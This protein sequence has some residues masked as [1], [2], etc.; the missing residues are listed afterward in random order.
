MGVLEADGTLRAVN[1]ALAGVFG[2]EPEVVVGECVLEL[3][4]P[5]DAGA[6]AAAL[7]TALESPD[8]SVSL[9][10]RLLRPDGSWREVGGSLTNALNDPVVSGLVLTFEAASG[11][12]EL[13]RRNRDLETRLGKRTAQ[14]A[15][16]LR[17][18]E[19]SAELL[20]LSQER[21]R[22]LVSNASDLITIL[23]ADG[24]IRY[25]SPAIERLLGY[26]E[27]ELIGRNA[28]DYVHPDDLPRLCSRFEGVERG[29]GAR[30]TA[31][32]RFRHSNGSWRYLEAIATNLIDDPSVAGIVVN[33]RDVTERRQAE[34][35]RS[36]SEALYR[37][38]IERAAEN[39]FIVDVET[40]GII[41][42]NEALSRSLGYPPDEL[43][44]M[45]FYDIVAHDRE[46]VD[47]DIRWILQSGGRF[48]GERRYRGKNGAVVTVEVNV[49]AITYG[50]REALCI[51]AHD[52]TERKRAE[53]SLR[54]SLGVLLALREAGQVLGSTL[55]STEIVS[56]LLEIMQHVS[57]LDAT[58]IS[59]LDESGRLSV[60]RS[61]GL[62]TLRPGIRF[63]P[64]AMA[65]RRAAL[66]NE[67][68]V[69]RP[70]DG[71]LQ[72]NCQVV[73]C[74]PL[75]ARDKIIGVLEAFGPESLAQDDTVQILS[76]LTGQAASA[77]ENARLYKDLEER[78]QQLQ[79]LIERLLAAQEEERRRVAYEVH[80]GLA[81]VAA[82][83]HQHLQ[84]FARRYAPDTEKGRQDLARVLKLV[85]ATVSDARRI[86]ANLRPTTLD[87]FGLATTLSVEAETL[88][89]EGYEVDCRHNL[90]ED[91]LS[92]PVEI[93][94]FRVAQEAL[95]NMR[96]HSDARY[97]RIVL[98][99]QEG[100]V[101]LEV[102]D[103]GRGF[104]PATMSAGSGPGERV[105]L[106]GMRERVS[107]LGGRLE[108]NS[109]PG[110]GTSVIATVPLAGVA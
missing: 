30:V 91:R 38:V 40:R 39:I 105:G 64:E 65:A 9:T 80:D 95:N 53:D 28:F 51:V 7:A 58:V 74:I 107:M 24:T 66:R 12:E 101:R 110:Y 27:D 87:D 102:S 50:G 48:V 42:A 17:E 41:E 88:R 106:A 60:R 4:H 94:L 109:R 19:D 29:S 14:L 37:T 45:V 22:S 69:F 98:Q 78:E 79:D 32:F 3:V 77:L 71:Y 31:E 6:A 34:E 47:D 89:E 72:A 5:E 43:R 26:G 25:E 55:E 15:A 85:R 97:V 2:R 62:N 33:S 20:R 99:R 83:A 61:L 18:V 70:G 104:D 108:I 46:S 73:L 63:V 68:T 11:R 81:Q 57:R 92:H 75:K 100:E 52:I 67:T 13:L 21:F 10:L 84:A 36:R 90:A 56:R 35:D 96:K 1:S 44:G 103:F 93:A 54:E 8:E 23:D 16:T 76:S 59:M 49:S 82:A 86:I